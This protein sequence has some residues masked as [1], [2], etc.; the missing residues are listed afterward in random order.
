DIVLDPAV[1]VQVNNEDNGTNTAFSSAETKTDN[2]NTI[3]TK[4]SEQND[5]TKKTTTT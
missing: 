4:L 2:V 3:D 1:P 5:I